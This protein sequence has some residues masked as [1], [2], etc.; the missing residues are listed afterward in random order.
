[1]RPGHRVAASLPVVAFAAIA[2]ATDTWT[3]VAPGFGLPRVDGF[4]TAW[5]WSDFQQAT[6]EA[7][8]LGSPEGGE[9]TLARGETAQVWFDLRNTG[10][11]PFRSGVTKL[12]PIQRD[13]PS[14]V[15]GPDW[16]DA[17]ARTGRTPRAT[18]TSARPTAQ[19]RHGTSLQTSEDAGPL[20]SNDDTPSLSSND[21]MA[22]TSASGDKMI[23][24]LGA[25]IDLSR[26]HADGPGVPD[27]DSNPC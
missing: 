25:D 16:P 15:A 10:L 18:E 21:D 23:V 9:L 4:G 8:S 5:C 27:A 24:L 1:M 13:V 2:H 17:R 12:A 19:L 22:T 14:P 20:S 26:P 7:S 3:N 6:P 11:T